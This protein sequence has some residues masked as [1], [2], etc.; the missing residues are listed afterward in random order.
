[1]NDEHDFD[2]QP[3]WSPIEGDHSEAQISQLIS[4]LDDADDPRVLDLG[5][6]NGRILFPLAEEGCKVMGLD[7]DRLAIEAANDELQSLDKDAQ[8][9]IALKKLDFLEETAEGTFD[10]ASFDLVLCLGHTFMLIADIFDACS[11]LLRAKAWLKPGGRMVIDDSPFQCWA[12]IADGHWQSGLSEDGSQQMLFVP[13]D[14]VF[15]LREGDA[16]DE[17]DDH[18]NDRD[19]LLRLWSMGSLRLLAEC[20][21]FGQP[22]HHENAGLISFSKKK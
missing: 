17:Q 20:T 3:D 9:R 19:D 18:P 12:D 16:V 11:V 7:H 22:V 10:A 2:D 21:G 15:V 14:D 13:G 1:M 6:G 8:S 5:C 4:W